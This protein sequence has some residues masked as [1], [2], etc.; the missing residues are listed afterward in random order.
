MLGVEL[1]ALLRKKEKELQSAS[2][3]HTGR[4]SSAW[5]FGKNTELLF[6]FA[7]LPKFC[8]RRRCLLR[9]L[10]TLVPEQQGYPLQRG[11]DVGGCAIGV[12]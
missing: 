3:R 5:Q 4:T 2:A 7:I 6:S 10:A 1:H 8:A 11:I 9:H 12:D